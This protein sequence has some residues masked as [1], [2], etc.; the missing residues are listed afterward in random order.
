M[1]AIL[2][3]TVTGTNGVIVPPDGYLQGVR[4]LRPSRHPAYLRRGDDRL[5]PHR[6]LVHG[7][8]HWQVVPDMRSPWL[9]G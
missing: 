5:S 9:R 6:R 2:M 1:A 7:V 4:D 8:D 3:E